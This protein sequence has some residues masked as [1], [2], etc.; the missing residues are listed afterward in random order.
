M[1]VPPTHLYCLS[2][3]HKRCVCVCV[4]STYIS[5]WEVTLGA[6]L[7]KQIQH[8]PLQAEKEKDFIVHAASEQLFGSVGGGFP[9]VHI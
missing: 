6:F 4:S 1:C 8:I 9:V 5:Q 2:S 7:P 3:V